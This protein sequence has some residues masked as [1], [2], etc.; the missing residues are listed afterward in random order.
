MIN[1]NLL[2]VVLVVQEQKLCHVG[3]INTP[4]THHRLEWFNLCSISDDDLSNYKVIYVY[5]TNV[6][7]CIYS[8]F[9]HHNMPDNPIR[10][11]QCNVQCSGIYTLKQV[12]EA[13]KDLYDLEEFFD[14][15][16]LPPKNG[17]KRNYE[18]IPMEY[19]QFWDD[20]PTFNK[21]LDLPNDPE[22]YPVKKETEREQF[23]KTELTEIYQ[24]LIDK[25]CAF[26]KATLEKPL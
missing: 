2:F 21:L 4:N 8:R 5:R 22:I 15:Y 3:T 9:M 19:E 7:N 11:H 20:I 12:I 23:Y 6:L 1:K 24:P 17:N 13:K 14:N 10:Y 18:I 26:K 16:T 25:M